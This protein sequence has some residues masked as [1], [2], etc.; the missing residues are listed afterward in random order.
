MQ[1][2]DF[3]RLILLPDERRVLLDGQVLSIG[4][5]AFDVLAVLVASRERIVG[6]RE[7]IESAW[8]GLVVEDN[9]LT[10]QISSLR[11]LLGADAIANVPGRGYRFN[12]AGLQARA[13]MAEMAL[14]RGNLPRIV[15]PLYGRDEHASEVAELCTGA[16]LL[17]LCGTGGIGKT[18]LALLSAQRLAGSFT[19]GA[20]W[21]E[22]SAVLD[23][24]QVLPQIAQALGITLSGRAAA[25]EELVA[26]LR[27]RSMLIVLDNCEHQL[28]PVAPFVAALMRH[29][30]DVHL[31]T[32]SQEPLRVAGERIFR[33]APLAIPATED[34][35]QAESFGAIRLL[36]ERVR[37]LQG[38][39]R[40]DAQ[41]TG[42]AIDICRHL[43]GNAL[44]IE[45][46]A[47]CVPL[48]GLATVL[49]GLD[50]RM[51][52][53]T[54]GARSTLPR[55]RSLRAALE[56]SHQLLATE[57]QVA[58]RRLSV[59][60]GSFSLEGAQRL[61]GEA[62]GDAAVTGAAVSHLRALADRSLL[63]IE[64]GAR[65]RYRM[66]E[67]MR[68]FGLERL[69]AAGETLAW[70]RRHAHAMREVCL[71]AARERDA[72]WMAAE[73]S[74]ARTALDWA[75][76][77]P[78]EGLTAVTIATSIAVVLA[79]AGQVSEVIGNLQKVRH[80]VDA[81]TPAPL[82]AR[83]W[84]RLGRFGMEGGLP[85]S[86]CVAALTRAAAMFEAE[87]N[88]RH[89]HACHRMLAEAHIRSGRPE[90]ARTHLKA[91]VEVESAATPPAD[92]MRR[93]RIAAL[94]ADANGEFDESLRLTRRALD[95]A[96][97]HR[98]QL[99]CLLLGSDM[100]WVQLRKGDPA[101]AA[102]RLRHL[103]AQI[104]P[105]PRRGLV[106]AYALAGY[107]AALV[108]CGRLDEARSMAGETI[109]ALQGSGIFL[110]RGDIFAWLA[111]ASGQAAL[112]AQ[113]LGASDEFHA[114]GEI[115]RDRISQHACEQAHQLIARE[116]P[117]PDAAFWADQGRKT[118]EALLA[119]LLAT[120]L[121]RRHAAHSP[122]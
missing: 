56:W 6:K 38:D 72:A 43:D 106:H 35:A 92:L 31:L 22:L 59:F 111:A 47:A 7:L 64:S 32:T 28:E 39:Y 17:T 23:A 61:V 105:G 82:A 49:A 93:L 29:A 37:A 114:R 63:V 110:A 5:R 33:V 115:C 80:L 3:G 41:D 51:S 120:K 40:L 55:H 121:D 76:A 66:L 14:R 24:R 96:E 21:V 71:L 85:N 36:V 2:L 113:L 75:V 109:E 91:A 62:A 77:T 99:Y 90:P 84:Q 19:H 70:R 25:Q 119:H 122:D 58:L 15:T 60:T 73:T 97:T 52:L 46:A 53:L 67:S 117:P 50:E 104:E 98:L 88:Q 112:A 48:L 89:R 95:I 26:A 27:N 78:G 45:L 108:A 16:A 54:H 9:N 83:F 57:E 11:K 30:A 10:V 68:V 87:G 100:A 65:P 69:D 102:D 20:W 44:A 86:E 118:D 42:I 1:A 4:S 34:F 107:L 81:A 79:T 8:Q 13:E 94:L 101:G 12:A 116:M 18:S 103:L 74:N